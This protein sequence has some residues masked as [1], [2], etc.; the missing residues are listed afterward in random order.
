MC[1]AYVS[2]WE[3]ERKPGLLAALAAVRFSSAEGFQAPLGSHSISTRGSI[4]WHHTY[5]LGPVDSVI[6]RD[7]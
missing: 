4:P 2:A 6:P 7:F 5:R 3:E 1:L